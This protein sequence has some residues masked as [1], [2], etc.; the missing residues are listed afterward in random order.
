MKIFFIIAILLSGLNTINA[1]TNPPTGPAADKAIKAYSEGKLNELAAAMPTLKKAYPNHPYTIFFAAHVADRLDNNVSEALRGYSEVI[2]SAPDLSDPFIFRAIIFNEKGKYQKAIDDMTKAIE[3][4]GDKMPNNFTLRG[5]IYA[6]A[7]NDSE[8]YQDF[9]KAIS[10]SP[11]LASNYR[12]IMN[13]GLLTGRKDEIISIL[14]NAVNGSEAQ[15][16]S[17]WEVWGDVNLR[18]KQF[19]TADKA[20]GKAIALDATNANADC[21]NS[22]AI[23]ALNTNQFVKAKQ[24]AEKA[25]SLAPKNHLF[26][27]N[28]SEI[29]IQDKTWEEVYTWAQKALQVNEKSA[30]ANLLMAIGV[31]RTNRGDALSAEYEKKSKQLQEDGVQD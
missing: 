7:G 5:N 4:E 9:K 23:A 21:Y 11:N 13:T 3:L 12:G 18:T 2:K 6:N 15:N 31:K 24:L 10:L 30:R 14:S 29:S 20:Y 1:Q 27:C 28:R 22:A 25:I 16:G 26:Y 8:A 19:A 17:V